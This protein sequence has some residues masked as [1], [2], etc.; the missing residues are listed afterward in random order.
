M[1]Q[2]RYGGPGQQAAYT[3]VVDVDVGVEVLV[4][5]LV[6]VEELQGKTH[7]VYKTVGHDPSA[8]VHMLMPQEGRTTY[9]VELVEVLVGVLVDVEELQRKT[10]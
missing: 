9:S 10:Q 2:F 4:G 1:Q 3:V 5:V 8:L 7:L 6:D